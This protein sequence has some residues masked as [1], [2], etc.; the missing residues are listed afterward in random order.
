MDY[1]F[2]KLILESIQLIFYTLHLGDH[3]KIKMWAEDCFPN[4]NYLS[5]EVWNS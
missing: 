4:H 2:T 5:K 1:R 3:V